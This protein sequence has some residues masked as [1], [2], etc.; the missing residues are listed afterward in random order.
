MATDDETAPTD[1]SP[2]EAR[3]QLVRLIV[4]QDIERHRE[5]YDELKRE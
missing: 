2:A 1:H 4:R 3:R 5:V